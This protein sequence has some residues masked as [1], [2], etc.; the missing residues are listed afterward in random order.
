MQNLI[1][2]LEQDHDLIRT[3]A[4]YI[5]ISEANVDQK[6]KHF[7]KFANLLL[8]HI[9]SEEQSIYSPYRGIN[10][11]HLQAVIQTGLQQHHLIKQAIGRVRNATSEEE[12]TV[13]YKCLG[14]LIEYHL[15]EEE[16]EF[17]P[18]LSRAVSKEQLESAAQHYTRLSP[19]TSAQA[20]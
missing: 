14:Q 1:E 13:E 20:F 3:L 5:R 12:W 9:R 18:E 19:E 16:S 7:E 6:K 17:F 11:P 2:F 10:N 15:G 8:G 4:N